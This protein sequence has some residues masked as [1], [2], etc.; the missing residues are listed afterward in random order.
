[1]LLVNFG[2]PDS[3]GLSAVRAFLSEVFKEHL[4]SVPWPLREWW[5]V[6]RRLVSTAKKYQA[7]WTPQGS[8]LLVQ[9]ALF[10]KALASTLTD[11]A[12]VLGM[13]FGS[14]SIE[15]AL[16]A[17]RP[18]GIEELCV[19][20]FISAPSI[21]RRVV[22]ATASWPQPPRIR[23][24]DCTREPWYGSLLSRRLAEARPERFERVVFSFHGLPVRPFPSYREEC[25]IAAKT[26]AA[27]LS[28]DKVCASFQSKA[29]KG[30]T[31]PSTK[32][33]LAALA[34]SGVQR[35]LVICPSF[36][37]DCLETLYEVGVERRS[38]FLR[39]G[40]KEL[41]LLPSLNQF[42]PWVEA[43]SALVQGAS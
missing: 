3:P 25:L 39:R 43:V 10:A 21:S 40:G 29:G 14:P 27:G 4:S 9:S 28:E 34:D 42:Q 38:E 11:S 1:M 20:S 2:T 36:V 22:Q 6:P 16:E 35:V 13:Q 23:I 31:E 17:L 7:I 8:P 37:V 5:I 33:V 19:A 30:W 32:E 24:K 18:L 26:I 12:V 41:M 15:E